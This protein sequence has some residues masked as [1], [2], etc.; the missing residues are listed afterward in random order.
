MT[1]SRK[2]SWPA[3]A[4]MSG[5]ERCGAWRVPVRASSTKKSTAEWDASDPAPAG[6][7]RALARGNSWSKSSLSPACI[8]NTANRASRSERCGRDRPIWPGLRDCALAV[9][10]TLCLPQPEQLPGPQ[11]LGTWSG[12]IVRSVN[13]TVKSVTGYVPAGLARASRPVQLGARRRSGSQR[14]PV[15][16]ST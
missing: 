12:T 11:I 8:L 6:G 14:N 3:M 16:R 9:V 4:R 15:S 10:V 7:V 1:C 2:M 5:F 13:W